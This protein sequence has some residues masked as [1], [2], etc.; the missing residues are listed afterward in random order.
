MRSLPTGQ[1]PP[2]TAYIIA[3]VCRAS[4][5][6]FGSTD[7][8][9]STTLFLRSYAQSVLGPFEGHRNSTVIVLLSGAGCGLGHCA[10]LRHS[11]HRPHAFSRCVESTTSHAECN[12]LL[13]GNRTNPTQYQPRCFRTHVTTDTGSSAPEAWRWYCTMGESWK[14]LLREER[15][16][17]IRHTRVLFSRIDLLYSSS[18]GRWDRYTAPWHSAHWGCPDMFWVLSRN[19]AA[20][21]LGRTFLEQLRCSPG[22]PCCDTRWHTSWWPWSFWIHPWRGTPAVCGVHGSFN[23]TENPAKQR[24]VTPCLASAAPPF[25]DREGRLTDRMHRWTV[26]RWVGFAH[27][28]PMNATNISTVYKHYAPLELVDRET[29][30]IC[31]SP[32]H[33][34]ADRLVR[35]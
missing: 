11:M 31:G 8:S 30:G 16:T 12:R 3:G 10:E 25:A 5:A 32:T 21:V 35:V 17:G 24:A 18:M 7:S 19:L 27:H 1:A 6:L 9:T 23:L 28:I 26:W 13:R 29:Q 2:I 34:A 14:L 20:K 33:A 22:H 4:P 15:R